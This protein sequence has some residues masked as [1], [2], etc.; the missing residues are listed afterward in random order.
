MPD[1]LVQHVDGLLA[2]RIRALAKRRQ[3]S[4]HDVLVAVLR[5]GLRSPTVPIAG[6]PCTIRARCVVLDAHWEA[7]ERGALQAALQADA[8]PTQLA[9]ERKRYGEP[10]PGAE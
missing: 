9:P 3:C 2:E 7:T 8:H 10:D 4:A 5:T 6:R 1:L